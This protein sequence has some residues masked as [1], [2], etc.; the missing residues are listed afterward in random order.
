VF[1]ELG[2]EQVSYPLSEL[3]A[4][5]EESVVALRFRY[6]QAVEGELMLPE[7]FEPNGISVVANVSSPRKA[8]AREQYPW[9]LQER[10]T[11]AG[12]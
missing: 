1:G 6:F 8:E 9:Q 11:H 10:F 12:K 2:E 3:S 7:G 5:L 4:D